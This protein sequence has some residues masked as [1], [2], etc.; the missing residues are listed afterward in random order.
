MMSLKNVELGEQKFQKVIK[1]KESK[2]L[3]IIAVDKNSGEKYTLMQI[4]EL[5]FILS[6]ID[7]FFELGIESQE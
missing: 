5:V 6:G 1:L 7:L 2:N 4:K 3:N